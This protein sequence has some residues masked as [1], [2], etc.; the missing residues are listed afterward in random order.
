MQMFG[1]RALR[2][3]VLERTRP[4]Q[5]MCNRRCFE[6]FPPYCW[7]LAAEAKNP[8]EPLLLP[9]EQFQGQR[10]GCDDSKCVSPLANLLASLTDALFINVGTA[11]IHSQELLSE[12]HLHNGMA[13]LGLRLCRNVPINGSASNVAIL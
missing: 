3:R 5:H 2:K 13:R 6:A 11:F 1:M 7:S 8:R 9:Q 4:G 12:A 10:S